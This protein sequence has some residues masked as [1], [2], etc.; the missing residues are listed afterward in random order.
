[1]LRRIYLYSINP[2]QEMCATEVDHADHT[3]P[4]RQHQPDHTDQE[5]IC[6]ERARSSSEDR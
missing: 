6:H 3:A 5:A 1:M 2:T 4:T